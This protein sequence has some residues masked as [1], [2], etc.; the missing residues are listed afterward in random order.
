M[1]PEEV[2]R[3]LEAEF[4]EAIVETVVEGGH[5]HA[6]VA[7]EAWPKVARFLRDDPRTRFNFLRSVSSLDLTAD[8]K[9]ACV[10]D[11]NHIPTDTPTKLITERR[12]FAVRVETDRDSPVIPS[13]ADLWPTADWHEREAMDLMGITFA[14]HPDPRR[15][16][17]PYDW[18]GYPLRKDYEYPLEYHGIPARRSMS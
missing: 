17:L 2:C 10:Y 1:A 16:L 4:G 15:I 12:E 14:G 9:L 7:P 3:L 8:N 6:V 18:D 13:V 5:P 11:M